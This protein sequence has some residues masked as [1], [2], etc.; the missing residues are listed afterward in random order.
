MCYGLQRELACILFQALDALVPQQP[1]HKDII[2]RPG[3]TY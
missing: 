1:P 2:I 3:F